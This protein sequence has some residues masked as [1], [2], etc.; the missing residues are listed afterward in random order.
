MEV[1][2]ISDL[3]SAAH[4]FVGYMEFGVVF[5]KSHAIRTNSSGSDSQEHMPQLLSDGMKT[6]EGKRICTFPTWKM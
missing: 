3:W 5:E 1:G 4:L 2:F 6:I